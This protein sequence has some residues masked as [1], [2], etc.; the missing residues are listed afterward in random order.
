VRVALSAKYTENLFT[1]RK[2]LSRFLDADG[3]DPSLL[4]PLFQRQRNVLNLA[5]YHG[6]I[7]IHRPFLLSNFASLNSR[8][9]RSRGGPGTPEMDKNVNECLDAAMRIAA[10]VEELTEGQQIY[11]AFWVS[12]YLLYLISTGA[13]PE[14]S[15][16]I[17]HSVRL[18]YSTCIQ[19]SSVMNP[20]K[21]IKLI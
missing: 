14:S 11:R 12:L 18:S 1:W 7:L 8:S 5:Y 9:K 3:F 19:S 15:P 10:I 6:L 20:E 21:N 17:L 13:D 4:I 16:I 2:S